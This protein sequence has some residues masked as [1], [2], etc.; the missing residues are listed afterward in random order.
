MPAITLEFF[1]KT[2]LNGLYDESGYQ[3]N[4]DDNSLHFDTV[5]NIELMELCALSSI[6]FAVSVAVNEFAVKVLR[7][8]SLF[9][10]SSPD[11]DCVYKDP[12]LLLKSFTYF[13]Y[14]I[15]L[16]MKCMKGRKSLYGTYLGTFRKIVGHCFKGTAVLY[17]FRSETDGMKFSNTEYL[18]NEGHSKF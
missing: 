4:D 8:V 12:K 11:A 9:F 1:T 16:E 10:C 3:C 15:N 6:E 14:Y 2:V 13:E 18:K 5:L 17:L 7:E